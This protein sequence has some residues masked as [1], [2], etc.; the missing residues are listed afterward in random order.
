MPFAVF[1]K[2]AVWGGTCDIGDCH[3]RIRLRHNS[4][5][6]KGRRLEVWFRHSELDEV[7]PFEK[8]TL[9]GYV[10]IQGSFQKGNRKCVFRRIENV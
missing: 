2:N 9:V 3:C 1:K 4:E 8:S 10:E 7:L 6:E 5:G